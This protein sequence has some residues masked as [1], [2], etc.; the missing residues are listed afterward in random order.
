LDEWLIIKIEFSFIFVFLNENFNLITCNFFSF[1]EFHIFNGV[2]K[3]M[4][5]PI[6]KLLRIG[7]LM[8]FLFS[9]LG[10]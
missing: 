7:G 5:Y 1:M 4:E 3:I 8:S 9:L 10:S 6:E 2:Y